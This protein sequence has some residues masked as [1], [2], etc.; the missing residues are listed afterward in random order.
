MA[1]PE[2]DS[3]ASSAAAYT[4]PAEHLADETSLARMLLVRAVGKRRPEGVPP[5]MPSGADLDDAIVGL[6]RA[7]A[8]RAAAA[9]AAG[10]P[11]PLDR[12]REVF[13][14]SSGE[15]RALGVLVA[16]E[17]DAELRE[18]ARFLVGDPSRPQPDVGLLQLLLYE[19]IPERALADLRADGA[20]FRFA[21]VQDLDAGRDVAFV[22]RRLRIADRVL[23][24]AHGFDRLDRE[25]TGT[26]ELVSGESSLEPLVAQEAPQRQ[27]AR[28]L[29]AAIAASGGTRTH[30]AIVVAGPEGAGRKALVYRA[31]AELGYPVLRVRCDRLPA[32]EGPLGMLGRTIMREAM[33]WDAV[34][35]LEDADELAPT[36]RE[37]G[38]DRILLAGMTGPL[39]ATAGRAEGR[40]L[41]FDRG[42]VLV[43]LDLPEESDRAA[44]WARGLGRDAP[45]ELLTWSAARYSLSPGRI[46]RASEAAR[47]L[48]AAR[49]SDGDSPTATRA[50][51]HHAVRSTLDGKLSKLGMRV[52]WR[53][54]WEDVVLPGDTM[55]E[56]REL[57]ARVKHRR[58]VHED[59]GFA[60]KV[61]KGLGIS[62]LFSGPP[63]TGKTMVA[64]LIAGELGLD[65]YQ[66]DLS[67]I[68]SKWVGETEKNLSELFDAAEA[69]H[70]ILLFDEADSLFAKRTQV[71]SS[72]DRYANLEVNYLLQRMESFRGMSIL[73]TNHDAA[74]DDAFR[75]RLSCRIDFPTPESEERELLWRALL[76]D[77]AMS[78]EEPDLRRLA[79][80]YQMS[81][82]HIRN[83]VL[84]AAF[85]AADE[86]ARIEMRHLVHAANLEYAAVGKVMS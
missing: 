70:A 56:V 40:P 27:V 85:L 61:A 26:C 45:A 20:L 16:L 22:L 6:V 77:V 62:A 75:R 25:L 31:A 24:L 86:G 80:K 4:S 67:R 68:V 76:P 41:H 5:G 74:I 63:G 83:A 47:A 64:G 53:Q 55:L 1:P 82:G 73:T 33:W 59:W 21:L 39:V 17:M 79:N 35:L 7:S 8:A 30:P 37:A 14:L 48:G 43:H 34:L 69:G 84:R 66:V 60:A 42:V 29:V 57:I 12:L 52:T 81:G 10:T 9:R 65:L 50:D 2:T 72:V 51:I 32:E 23:E 13:G 78:D 49:S 11:M 28:L 18:L 46:L 19:G 15:Q 54:R 44:M 3:P 71:S 38:I 36:L 58:Q